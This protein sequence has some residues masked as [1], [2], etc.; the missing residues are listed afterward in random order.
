MLKVLTI[1]RDRLTAAR[2]IP[3]TD[4][5]QAVGGVRYRATLS[6]L[7]PHNSI[8]TSLFT[9]AKFHARCIISP[10]STQRGARLPWKLV[11]YENQMTP[12]T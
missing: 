1:Y 2:A 10:V 8:L 5:G 7:F 11:A 4:V 3:R 12:K 9:L 6:H